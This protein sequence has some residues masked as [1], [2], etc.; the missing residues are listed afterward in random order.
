MTIN[1]DNPE[2]RAALIERVGPAEYGRKLEKHRERIIVGTV[3]GHKIRP[4]MSRFGRLFHVG[5]TGTAFLTM[6]EAIEFA[7]KQP[8]A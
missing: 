6:G 2:E 5:D 8:A 1:F 7:K 3:N 4:V